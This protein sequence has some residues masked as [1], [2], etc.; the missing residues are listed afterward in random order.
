VGFCTSFP[1]L[2]R[3]FLTAAREKETP[4]CPIGPLSVPDRRL[5][6]PRAAH[7]SPP[8]F[9]R[10]RFPS[11]IRGSGP[12]AQLRTRFLGNSF[13]GPSLSSSAENTPRGCTVFSSPANRSVSDRTLCGATPFLPLR[14]SKQCSWLG[15][16][17]HAFPFR[18]FS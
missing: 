6:G 14:G 17:S 4:P 5:R 16:F 10:G 12:R 1:P 2:L 9:F 11:F 3:F 13:L 18:V 7:P 8:W 15:F